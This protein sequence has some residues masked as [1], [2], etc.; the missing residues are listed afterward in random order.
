MNFRGRIPVTGFPRLD[1]REWIS[2]DGSCDV[3]AKTVNFEPFFFDIPF[4]RIGVDF[5]SYGSLQVISLHFS[6]G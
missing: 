1:F 6:A 2:A 3:A 5:A 4:F